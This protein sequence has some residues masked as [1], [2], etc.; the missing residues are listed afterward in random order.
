MAVGIRHWGLA[1]AADVVDP[2]EA[3]GAG[4]VGG[5]PGEGGRR[6]DAADR[7]AE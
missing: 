5:G 2:L 6:H 3:A 4:A 7:E 1:G